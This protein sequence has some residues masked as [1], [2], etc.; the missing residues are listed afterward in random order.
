MSWQT[1]VDVVCR[2]EFAANGTLNN[3]AN[4]M[5]SR[6]INEYVCQIESHSQLKNGK[7]AYSHWPVFPISV[8]LGNVDSSTEPIVWVVGFVR[9]PSISYTTDNQIAHLRPY[10]TTQYSAVE[11]AVC[12]TI[13]SSFCTLTRV[14]L[15]AFLLDF[16]NSLSRAEVLDAQMREDAARVSP[17]GKLFDMLSLATRQVFGSLEVT[18][19]QGEGN[20]TRIF[21]KDMGMTKLNHVHSRRLLANP[22]RGVAQSGHT[23]RKTIRRLAYVPVLQCNTSEAPPR[24]SARTAS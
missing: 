21:M 7:P 5:T 16:N 20:E 17:D 23:G 8:N 11:S 10:Y 12:V 1:C 18:A 2:T 3:N 4:N 24:A 13:Y 9:D 15:E 22:A 14:Q 6:P 19:P